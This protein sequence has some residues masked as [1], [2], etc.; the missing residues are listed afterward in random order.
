MH[1]TCE[2][3]LTQ[4]VTDHSCGQLAGNLIFG[5]IFINVLRFNIYNQNGRIYYDQRKHDHALQIFGVLNWNRLIAIACPFHAI[6]IAVQIILSV[7]GVLSA[8]H[9]A[10]THDMLIFPSTNT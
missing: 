8:G 4:C 7:D 3:N 10:S 5:I 9:E 2:S 1:L 6:F